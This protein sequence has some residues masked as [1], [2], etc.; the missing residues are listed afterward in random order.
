[1]NK[2]SYIAL[3]FLTAIAAWLFR[4]DLVAASDNSVVYRLDRW[5]GSILAAGTTGTR[6]LKP[7]P[8]PPANPFDKFD[9]K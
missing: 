6:E 5:T 8:Q 3:I 2:P 9:P 1:M 4:Y 7:I